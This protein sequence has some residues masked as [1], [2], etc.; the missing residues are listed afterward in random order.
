MHSIFNSF[1]IQA[2]TFPRQISLFL[3]EQN[4]K[5]IMVVSI[6]FGV[7]AASCYIFSHFCLKNLSIKNRLDNDDDYYYFLPTY[8]PKSLNQSIPLKGQDDILSLTANM[9]KNVITRAPLYE[10][11]IQNLEDKLPISNFQINNYN[12][13]HEMIEFLIECGT[14]GDPE[15]QALWD[16]TSRNL[17]LVGGKTD[18]PQV[19]SNGCSFKVAQDHLFW[20]RINL[21]TIDETGEIHICGRLPAVYADSVK[22]RDEEDQLLITLNNQVKPP[23]S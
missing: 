17:Y 14:A 5:I 20:I 3:S 8:A 22:Y 13:N 19:S 4:K 9:S 6:I 2:T 7:L 21:N 23:R 12:I 11:E 10:I 15:I 1:H 18:A 16:K